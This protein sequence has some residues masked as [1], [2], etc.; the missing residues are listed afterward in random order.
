MAIRCGSLK[1]VALNVS[2][3]DYSNLLCSAKVTYFGD[4]EASELFDILYSRLRRYIKLQMTDT[5]S[6]SNTELL[7]VSD[8]DICVMILP[9]NNGF[10]T[11]RGTLVNVCFYFDG[12]G[13]FDGN[14]IFDVI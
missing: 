2:Q 7:Y 3:T 12:T 11:N 1:R 6:L 5:V 8:G 14:G 10:V 13:I 4:S 9:T